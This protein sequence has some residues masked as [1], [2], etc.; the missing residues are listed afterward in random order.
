MKN[1][2]RWFVLLGLIVLPLIVA[3]IAVSALQASVD[4]RYDPDYFTAEYLDKYD[5]PGAAALGL[6]EALAAGDLQL[7]REL[8]ATEKGPSEFRAIPGIE[9]DELRNLD[10]DYYNYL[11]FSNDRRLRRIDHV[12]LVNGRYVVAEEDA[13]YLVDSG[14]WTA[15][16]APLMVTYYI[17]LLLGVGFVWLARR[18][19]KRRLERG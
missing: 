7:M 12:K 13:Y 18:S 10:G 17:L 16:F 2:R 19:A 8:V 4:T 3:G 14:Q 5:T 9:I 1:K 11:L 6:V 15:L